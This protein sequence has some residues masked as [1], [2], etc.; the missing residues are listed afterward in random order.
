L[1]QYPQHSVHLS[2]TKKQLKESRVKRPV[3]MGLHITAQPAGRY[4]CVQ[5]RPLKKE[6]P[7]GEKA[8]TSAPGNAFPAERLKLTRRGGGKTR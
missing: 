7:F 2:Y 6:D 4:S 5:Q 1:L 8:G 3:G